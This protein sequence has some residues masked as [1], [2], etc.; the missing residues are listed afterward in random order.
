MWKEIAVV[1]IICIINVGY[2]LA[3]GI[4]W[5]TYMISKEVSPEYKFALT[6]E[7]LQH[8][9]IWYL[10]NIFILLPKGYWIIFIPSL[11]VVSYMAGLLLIQ[12][13]RQ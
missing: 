4:I 2:G 6:F 9:A 11:F 10:L 12:V 7:A 3:V 8:F 13:H 1:L 5:R